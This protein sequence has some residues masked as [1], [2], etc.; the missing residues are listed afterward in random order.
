[1][2]N[3]T[4]QSYA[5]FTIG[6]IYDVMRHARKTREMWF[7]SYLFSWYMEKLIGELIDENNEF[8]TPYTDIDESTGTLV[9]N[10]SRAGKYH[11]RF[12]VRSSF[13]P[14]TLF[15]R[16]EAANNK[17]LSFLIDLSHTV[18]ACEKN[19]GQVVDKSR[20]GEIVSGYFQPRFF[21][22][23]SKEIDQTQPVASVD[24]FLDTLEESF[25]FSPGK[26]ADTCQ[27]CKTLPGVATARDI[28]DDK[29]IRL[30]LCPFCL[31]KLRANALPSFIPELKARLGNSLDAKD[32]LHY[33]SIPE[34]SARQVFDLPELASLKK[35]A[36]EVSD[37][38]EHVRRQFPDNK[39]QPLKTF[40]KYFAV[41][42]AD[43][44]NLGKLAGSVSDPTELSKRLFQFAEASEQRIKEFGGESVYLGG[45]DVLAFMPVYFYGK[46]VID[47]IQ[48]VSKDYSTMV[49]Q[50]A[51]KTTISFGCN[52]AYFKFPLSTA[53]DRAGG[54]LFGEAKEKKDSLALRFTRHSGAEL[55]FNLELGDQEFKL[56]QKL[57]GA[58]LN[59]TIEIPRGVHYNLSRFAPL[60]AGIPDKER[61]TA[62]FENNFNE[63][64]HDRYREGLD[65]II[66]LL[67]YFLK[68]GGEKADS[69]QDVLN[70]LKFIKFLTGDERS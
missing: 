8:L 11:D 16:I 51:G 65:Q 19:G 3:E 54:L 33:P 15:E 36:G 4:I 64:V 70:I 25:I 10:T 53:L 57:V 28:E 66:E 59:Q 41:V 32:R 27:R 45:D 18:A 69:V 62:F 56:F 37:V 14:K 49:D 44:D 23:P 35:K 21:A 12:V 43:G 7:G 58:V 50:G 9:L 48:T 40:H 46:T 47:F 29:E 55:K 20:I 61:L 31:L 2:T 63:A 1:M 34:I 17:T 13:L 26:S 5:G 22:V 6:P 38:F 30:T 60:F 24:R 68:R 67:Y 42:Q 52:I 39:N